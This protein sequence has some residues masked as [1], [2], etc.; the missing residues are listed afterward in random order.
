NCGEC[1][2]CCKYPYFYMSLF[3]PEF[4]LIRDYLKENQVPIEVEFEVLRLNDKRIFYKDWICPLY[5]F[6]NRQCGVYEV[7]PFSCRVYGPYS[8]LKGRIEGCVFENP[9]IYDYTD[10]LPF[11]K[12]Y[13]QAL[14]HFEELERGYIVPHSMT[15]QYPTVEFLMNYQL[16]WSFTRNFNKIIFQTQLK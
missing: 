6:K 7:R 1:N 16:P 5:D 2:K 3:T 12:D 14:N 11:W 13:A 8:T 9:I 4:N 10:D 15:F